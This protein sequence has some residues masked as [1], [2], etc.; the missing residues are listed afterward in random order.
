MANALRVA[1]L[2]LPEKFTDQELFSKIAGL[3]YR[4]D[5]RM[6]MGENP[7]KVSNIVDAQIDTFRDKYL[8]AIEELPNVN[9]LYD[10]MLQVHTSNISK[11]CQIAFV[12]I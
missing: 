7:H 3:S 2:L 10:G 4:G 1:L 9:Y 8:H 11:T 12:S 6:Q 5:F